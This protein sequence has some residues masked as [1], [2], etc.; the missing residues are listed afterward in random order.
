MWYALNKLLP[1]HFRNKDNI[2]QGIKTRYKPYNVWNF[3][4][5]FQNFKLITLMLYIYITRVKYAESNIVNKKYADARTFYRMRLFL[6]MYNKNW[7]LDEARVNFNL[8]DRDNWVYANISVYQYSG[9]RS[10]PSVTLG[11]NSK[12]KKF[13]IVIWNLN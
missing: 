7:K 12:L 13:A 9:T 6:V 1:L 8:R 3:F 2:Q 11:V 4:W 10:S 5:K